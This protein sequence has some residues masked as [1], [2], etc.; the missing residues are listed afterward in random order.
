MICDTRWMRGKCPNNDIV[1][2]RGIF[3]Y[4][5]VS[6]TRFRPEA[7]WRGLLQWISTC[8]FF[9]FPI[10]LSCRISENAGLRQGIPWPL[11][12]FGKGPCRPRTVPDDF[13][14]GCNEFSSD[15][16]EWVHTVFQLLLYWFLV[17]QAGATEMW[18]LSYIYGKRTN[19][20]FSSWF[21]CF[22][23]EQIAPYPHFGGKAF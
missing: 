5:G 4:H 10:G 7:L 23:S 21:S 3:P 22:H 2:R 11:R 1:R 15:G 12:R 8:A 13:S 9:S 6:R 18:K 17:G 19:R 20:I 14:L 16:R